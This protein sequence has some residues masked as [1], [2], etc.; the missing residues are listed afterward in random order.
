MID[1]LA[2][3]IKNNIIY[4]VI[5]IMNLI[6]LASFFIKK[7]SMNRLDIIRSIWRVFSLNEK[8]EKDWL[9][10][11]ENI[12]WSNYI[13]GE[14]K[15]SK[16]EN[17]I[18]EIVIGEHDS[19]ERNI[20]YVSKSKIKTSNPIIHEGMLVGNPSIPTLYFCF[21]KKITNYVFKTQGYEFLKD[22]II[23]LF[24]F[25]DVE[26]DKEF[27]R[28]LRQSRAKF[29]K[30]KSMVEINPPQTL[31]RG[32]SGVACLISKDKI[33][34]LFT[35]ADVFQSLKDAQSSLFKPNYKSKYEPMI[36]DLDRIGKFYGVDVYYTIVEKFNTEFAEDD[37]AKYVLDEALSI[38]KAKYDD[39]VGIYGK[40]ENITQKYLD[41]LSYYIYNELDVDTINDYNSFA[42]D[43][44][45]KTT[46]K[47]LIDNC[48]SKMASN[49]FDL[50][51]GNVGI[52]HRTNSLVFFDSSYYIE[53]KKTQLFKRELNKILKI[54]KQDDKIML[55]KDLI[56]QILSESVKTIEGSII[57]NKIIFNLDYKGNNL[58]GRKLEEVYNILQ[59]MAKNYNIDIVNFIT[60]Y[61]F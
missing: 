10:N 4:V 39:Y 6:S 8:Y 40:N 17:G 43:Y 46:I 41:E 13:E 28:M 44:G 53:N 52:S 5:N 19:E 48:L 58:K 1:I 2:L 15:D 30:I 34:K 61:N 57:S 25:E 38:I 54:K 50:H 20:L 35:G 21:A 16:F 49:R 9:E 23:K 60:I 24:N 29:D 55:A 59:K 37:D 18:L 26:F 22:L 11:F 7:Y 32:V 45:I 36:Y 3:Y 51:A 47:E 42:K 27:E 14:F 33:L 31:G 56:A 12:N